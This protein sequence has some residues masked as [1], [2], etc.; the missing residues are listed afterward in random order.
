MSYFIEIGVSCMEYKSKRAIKGKEYGFL[1][2]TG[3]AKTIGK[4]KYGLYKC[5]CGKEKYIEIGSVAYGN[6]KSCGCLYD[7]R[8]NEFGLKS[9]D[10][11][12]L[13]SVWKNM[14]ERCYKADS[15]RYYTYGARGIGVCDE[16][17]ENF[18]A[19]AKWAVDNGWRIGLSIE[20]KDLNRD[21]CPENCTFITMKEQARNKTSNIRIVYDG[22]DKCVAEWCEILGIDAKKVYARYARGIREPT[23]LFYEGN[24]KE[25]WKVGVT[26][27]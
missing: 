8:K 5:R 18:H 21:Y 16:W 24:L 10:Y 15:D 4:Y 19:F 9:Y 23:I 12:K 13:Y 22:Q 26:Y 7:S 25:L 20:R 11:E 27:A 2:Y 6:T 14:K 1:T 17:R 3:E